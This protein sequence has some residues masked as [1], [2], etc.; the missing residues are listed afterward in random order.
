M[1]VALPPH[2]NIPPCPNPQARVKN[3]EEQF[4]KMPQDLDRKLYTYR[5]MD[6]IKQ[7]RKQKVEIGKVQYKACVEQQGTLQMP[8]S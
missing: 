7:V 1:L 6:I 3:L 5:I 2:T 8:P 4:S